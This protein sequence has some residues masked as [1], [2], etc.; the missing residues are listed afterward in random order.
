[1]VLGIVKGEATEIETLELPEVVSNGLFG[2][3]PGTLNG[4][5]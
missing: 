4:Y 3:L 2:L 1:M 5:K